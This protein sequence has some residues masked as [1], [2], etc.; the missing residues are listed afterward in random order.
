MTIAQFIAAFD[1]LVPQGARYGDDN[2]GLHTGDARTEITSIL[3]AYEMDLSIVEEAA[4]KQCNLIV[5]YH[6]L[7]FTPLRRVVADDFI[8]AIVLRLAEKKIALFVAH[9]NF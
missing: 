3:V 5:C 9:T 7:V 1:H 4:A 6:P 2:A 8:G